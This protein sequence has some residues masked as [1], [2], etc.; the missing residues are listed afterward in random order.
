MSNIRNNNNN[1][2][3]N[4]N[5][6]TRYGD[7]GAGVDFLG[8]TM[9][10]R[11]MMNT[12]NNNNNYDNNNNNLNYFNSHSSYGP[13]VMDTFS[14]RIEAN[15]N[16]NNNNNGHTRQFASPEM[17]PN[18]RI[19]AGRTVSNQGTP[20]ALGEAGG[21]GHASSY[22]MQEEALNSNRNTNYND[23]Y[24]AGDS[25]RG[26]HTEQTQT[27]GGPNQG[28]LSAHSVSN[29]LRREP[30][31]QTFGSGF[32]ERNTNMN[33]DSNTNRV[34]GR[35]SPFSEF[36]G[37]LQQSLTGRTLDFRGLGENLNNARG[38]GVGS[39]S[40]VQGRSGS[41]VEIALNNDF[42]NS[43]P[44]QNAQLNSE[45]VEGNT[46]V[47]GNSAAETL[48]TGGNIVSA[49]GQSGVTQAGKETSA[50][51]TANLNI[52]E[53]IS[54]SAIKTGGQTAGNLN[55]GSPSH[56]AKF[57]AGANIHTARLNAEEMNSQEGGHNAG[58]LNFG[59]TN[60]AEGRNAGEM[61]FGNLVFPGQRNAG[62]LNAETPPLTGG[63]PTGEM[64]NRSFSTGV[65]VGSILSAHN[66]G[67]IST[68]S[69]SLVSVQNANEMNAEG[70]INNNR[71]M[72]RGNIDV[73]ELPPGLQ[74]SNQGSVPGGLQVFK[75]RS[76]SAGIPEGS[77][78]TDLGAVDFLFG[79]AAGNPGSTSLPG[80]SS[81]NL[82]PSKNIQIVV[83]DGGAAAGG[84][85]RGQTQIGQRQ[86]IGL[87]FLQGNFNRNENRNFNNNNNNR[88]VNNAVTRI[89]NNNNNA[90][91][92][93]E[94]FRGGGPM[95]IG[96]R[97][98]DTS[99]V[100]RVGK[101]VGSVP[102]GSTQVMGMFS[103]PSGVDL[104][105]VPD[106]VVAVPSSIERAAPR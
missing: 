101:P 84:I 87:D 102:A 100:G 14:N 1:N 72:S 105:S 95:S 44:T 22:R 62:E 55:A 25:F 64:H 42:F 47:G 54:G 32:A 51:L 59:T 20:F 90:N 19:E 33:Y 41:V 18:S 7:L 58:E 12:F 83:L 73:V 11:Q 71:Q 80:G 39:S 53:G 46:P 60:Q 34:E 85:G 21:V 37:S 5:I 77:T 70:G 99:S 104:P 48:K 8:Q 69:S 74:S 43:D 63:F 38:H 23:N 81:Q 3:Y 89:Y 6:G 61:N 65:N 92:N 27:L 24:F 91:G 9:L 17:P 96:G 31:Y 103:L 30:E 45:V 52:G 93:A 2:N 40:T 50:S 16:N 26:Q 57:N 36:G 56:A 67:K 79:G 10:Q 82:D 68:G 106:S 13:G 29:G 94:P 66:T 35:N 75:V 28:T 78:V 88:N 98:V 15:S 86:P 4:N 76:N 97:S 49:G